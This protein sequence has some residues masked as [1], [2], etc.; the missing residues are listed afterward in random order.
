MKYFLLILAA[1]GLLLSCEKPPGE[2]GTSTI[3]GRIWVEDYNDNFTLLENN[4]WAEEERVYII[5]GGDTSEFYDDD[6]RT[7]FNGLYEF[8]YLRPGTYSIFAY[9][10][11]STFTSLSGQVPVIRTVEITE[12]GQTI[13]VPQM[14]IFK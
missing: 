14:T 4:Y 1:T 13:E 8:N 10:L 5:Y 3:R 6:I 9:S 7:S 12:E 11:D 2:G